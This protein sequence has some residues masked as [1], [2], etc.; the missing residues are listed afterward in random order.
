MTISYITGGAAAA[1]TL[2]LPS[3]TIGDTIIGI[4]LAPAAGAVTISVPAGWWHSFAQ[5][6]SSGRSRA[7]ASK[8]VDDV[9]FTFGTWTTAEKVAYLIFRGSDGPVYPLNITG[10]P[11]GA[12]TSTLTHPSIN[13]TAFIVN[14][15]NIRALLIASANI[16]NNGAED[17]VASYTQVFRST[18][19]SNDLVC[20][21]SD[22]LLSSFGATTRTLDSATNNFG[23]TVLLKEIDFTIPTGGGDYTYDQVKQLRYKMRQGART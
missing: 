5:G 17:A 19:A 3:L 16:V 8:I 1:D 10:T 21:I 13:S 18:L 20:D 12:T 2:T 9:S 4:G 22:S 14:D 7:I 6:Q 23:A 15:N 11:T